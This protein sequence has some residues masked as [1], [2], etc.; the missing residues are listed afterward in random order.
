MLSHR[1]N[2]VLRQPFCSKGSFLIC[3][4][5]AFI[6]LATV[7]LCRHYHCLEHLLGLLQ[8]KFPAVL[9]TT[10]WTRLFDSILVFTIVMYGPKFK[11]PSMC[12]FEIRIDV[13]NWPPPRAIL[14]L[15]QFCV[16]W[17]W[18]WGATVRTLGVKAKYEHETCPVQANV[19]CLSPSLSSLLCSYSCL[20]ISHNATPQNLA[21]KPSLVCIGSAAM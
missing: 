2:T 20:E 14:L 7:C 3:V 6:V 10:V 9:S 16:H 5:L 19:M 4:T 1:P 18:A 8:R 11:L 21:Y 17:S 15:V 13:S 12:N